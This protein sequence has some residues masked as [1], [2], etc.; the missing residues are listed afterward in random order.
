MW[1]FKKKEVIEQAIIKYVKDP[2]SVNKFLKPIML[3]PPVVTESDI[4]VPEYKTDQAAGADLYACHPAAIP[5]GE[6]RIVHTGLKFEIPQ[7]WEIQIRSRSGLAAKEGIVVA[8]S[9]G[10]IDSD[11]RGL[12]GII[13]H[14][15]DP[16]VDKYIQKG[17]RV[18][19]M[20][21]ARVQC[22]SFKAVLKLESSG[23]GSG[24][25]GSTGK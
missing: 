12:I 25:F 5:A 11:Y 23:R 4:I 1:P 17:D 22:A 13:L 6:I 8:N 15:T 20:V 2:E 7:G 21:L 9:P 24:G 10:T 18:A 14:N 19:Q 3:R 16:K